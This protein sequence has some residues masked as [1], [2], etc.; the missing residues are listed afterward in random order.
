M[1]GQNEMGR[2][3]WMKCIISKSQSKPIPVLNNGLKFFLLHS[4]IEGIIIK[5]FQIWNKKEH[6]I[7]ISG[8]I[9]SYM[10][11]ILLYRCEEEIHS[12][13]ELTIHQLKWYSPTNIISLALWVLRPKLVLL[14]TEILQSLCLR[15]T[16]S[17]K[18]L[19]YYRKSR[20]TSHYITHIYWDTRYSDNL[21]CYGRS[22]WLLWNTPD[23]ML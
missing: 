3:H 15:N 14:L 9:S 13:I 5:D 16:I 1:P 21:T 17:F 4:L 22:G 19:R 6:N 12:E 8:V 18:H 10:G 20:D 11:P 23:I 7:I 2:S